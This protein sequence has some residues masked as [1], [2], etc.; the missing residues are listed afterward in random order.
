M[1]LAARG[2]DSVLA[3]DFGMVLITDLVSGLTGLPEIP[4]LAGTGLAAACLLAAGVTDLAEDFLASGF[5]A[6][7]AFFRAGLLVADL[8]EAVGR[9]AG[10]N[11]GFTTGLA[12]GLA[13]DLAGGLA[14]GLA[15]GLTADLAGSFTGLPDL[16]AGPL[17]DLGAGRVFAAVFTPLRAAGLAV[18]LDGGFPA[19]FTGAAG[20]FLTVLAAAFMIC[21]L[22]K[23]GRRAIVAAVQYTL[24]VQQKY[25]GESM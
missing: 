21:L 12:A 4:G 2:F 20:F 15:V 1:A 5:E 18:A 25:Y 11:A 22:A 19:A 24:A 8:G 10:F 14:V 3:A 13:K 23:L 16:T 9:A 7:N 17:A 6:G